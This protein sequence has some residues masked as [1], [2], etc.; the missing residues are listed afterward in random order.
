MSI[1]TNSLEWYFSLVLKFLIMKH[2]YLWLIPNA[3]C[4]S[5]WPRG[6]GRRFEATL[7]LRS[8]VR[9]PSG[10]LMFICCEC[11]V[12]SG[13]GLCD[14]LIT[15]PEESY[16]VWCVVDCDL[17]TSWMKRPWPTRGCRAKQTNKHPNAFYYL[18]LCRYLALFLLPF[19]VCKDQVPS[20]AQETRKTIHH[21]QI[22][23]DLVHHSEFS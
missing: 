7:L 3:V 11:C 15:L 18:N 14:E 5:Q 10:A 19:T 12:L 1:H 20:P 23:I 21:E 9:I 8:W 22:C 6:L 13:R 2:P 4:R 16:R 17:E